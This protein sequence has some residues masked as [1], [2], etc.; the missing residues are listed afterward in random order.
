MTLAP[1]A[2]GEDPGRTPPHRQMPQLLL[3]EW[4]LYFARF[5][6][7]YRLEEQQHREAEAKF[8]Q[9][10]DQTVQ[11][12][13]HGKWKVKKTSPSGPPV[14]VEQT[15]R[16][17]L[18]EFVAERA[19]ARDIESNE[20][21]TFG[22]DANARLQ[23]AKRDAAQLG[24][25][26]LG[27]PA[28]TAEW[29]KQLDALEQP[30]QNRNKLLKELSAE[31][32]EIEERLRKLPDSRAQEEKQSLARLRGREADVN[33]ELQGL[34]DKR[35]ALRNDLDLNKQTALMKE[36]LRDVLSAE[37]RKM[38]PLPEPIKP[39]WRDW[40]M[41]EWSDFLVKYGLTAVGICLIAGFLTRTACV[42]G[43][44][45][46]VFFYLAM[47][48]LPWLPESPRSEGH[49]LFINKNIIEMVA[50]LALATTLS[51]RWVGLDGL[52]RFLNPFRWRRRTAVESPVERTPVPPSQPRP[53]P[54]TR[55][56]AAATTQK[57][58]SWR[59]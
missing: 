32:K 34:L 23:V 57:P 21:A 48:A 20:I 53:Q 14:D 10:Q 52:I 18:D 1:L 51:G 36:S 59:D 54:A 41:L 49:Y 12:L 27:S 22:G 40:R 31:I 4:Q 43:A 28:R 55:P 26:L 2:A 11:W 50:L 37:Q 25:E 42:A 3:R 9:R 29:L 56:T 7:H 39:E 45:Y 8:L 38:E 47:P 15:T 33:S 6:D 17:R 19:R 13:L 16:E 44:L 58:R 46:L 35:Q 30:I 24:T 5:T